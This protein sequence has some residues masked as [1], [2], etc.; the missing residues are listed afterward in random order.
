MLPLGCHRV[1]ALY[2]PSQARKGNT[3]L[4]FALAFLYPSTNP[5]MGA[6]PSTPTLW[7]E[8]SRSRME[9]RQLRLPF[10]R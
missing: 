10:D 5:D 1:A 2:S 4:F 7:K 6:Y 3:H 9:K 8:V